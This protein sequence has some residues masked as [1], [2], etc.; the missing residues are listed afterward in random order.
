LTCALWLYCLDASAQTALPTI[1]PEQARLAQTIAGLAGP[2]FSLAFGEN[3]DYLAAACERHAILYWKRDV[4]QGIRSGRATPDILRAHEGPVVVL[5]S[6]GGR[7]LASG[8]TD[9]RILIWHM[10]EGKLV[11]RL[12]AK[13]IV[14]SLAIARGGKVLASA[15]DEHII[16]LW[17]PE[18]GKALAQMAGHAD[19]IVALAFDPP[20]KRLASAGFDGTLCIWD[21]STAKKVLAAPSQPLPQAKAP[22]EA[23]NA[24][25]ALAY[26]PDGKMLALG[27]SDGRIHLFDAN[28]GKFVRSLA[29]HQGPVT[30]VAFHPAGAVL[31][32]G[33]KDDTVRLW[34]TS[35][36]QLVK[37][38]EGHTA[39]VESIVFVARGARLASASADQTVRI[40]DLTPTK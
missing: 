4:W 8:G 1:A 3:A 36:G 13:G 10:P 23:A 17:D 19:W 33:S 2:A 32:S 35:G 6:D 28:D 12:P 7:L 20:G 40:W 27:G 39:W 25:L 5:A 21:V 22:P 24:A 18:S 11:R 16:Q 37:T 15:G 31:A 38:L 14:R 34:N 9:G 26:S 29:G 30:T